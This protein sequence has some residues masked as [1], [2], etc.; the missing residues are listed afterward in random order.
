MLDFHTIEQLRYDQ[1]NT[2]YSIFEV[3]LHQVPGGNVRTSRIS[4]EEFSRY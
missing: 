2:Q 3:T 4:H 1:I